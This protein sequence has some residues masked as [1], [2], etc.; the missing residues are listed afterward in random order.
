MPTLDSVTEWAAADAQS[1][2]LH[3]LL[4]WIAPVN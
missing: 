4:P 2:V 3:V 1:P